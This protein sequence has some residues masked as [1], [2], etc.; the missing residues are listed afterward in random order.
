MNVHFR[1]LLSMVLEP[2]AFTVPGSWEVISVDDFI[3]GF[4]DYNE[5]VDTKEA[6]GNKADEARA[7]GE[8]D[9]KIRTGAVDRAMQTE[10]EV[11]VKAD[12]EC[13]YRT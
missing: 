3:S 2:L 11:D 12:R 5:E 1:D 4:E 8:A 13:Q 6:S 7:A 9:P 10:V